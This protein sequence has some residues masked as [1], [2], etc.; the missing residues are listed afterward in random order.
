MAL[1]IR[2]GMVSNWADAQKDQK[3][4]RE[5]KLFCA[6]LAL[7]TAVAFWLL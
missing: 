4:A 2:E 6:A 3:K 5:L 7:I 1:D